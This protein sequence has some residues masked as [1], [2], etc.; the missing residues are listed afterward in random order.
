MPHES[1]SH[2]GAAGE[3]LEAL[4]EGVP[5]PYRRHLGIR[6]ELLLAFLPSVTALIAFWVVAMFTTQR[7]LFVSLAASAL[8][9]YADPR[10]DTNAIRTLIIAQL[11]A[12][13]IGYLAYL[14]L[15]PGIP[16]G[17]VAMAITI[18]L[19]ILLRRVHPPA[20][21]TTESFAIESGL[22]SNIAIFVL[23]LGVTAALVGL[24]WAVLRVLARLEATH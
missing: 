8:W 3:T 1:G 17:S 22:E 4:A 14:T 9:I 24:E 13:G 18:F 15:G 5:P 19:M 10:H 12:A 11:M 23:A 20:V 6:G 2:E 16:A 7:L 21:A